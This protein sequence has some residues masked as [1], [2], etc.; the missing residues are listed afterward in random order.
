MAKNCHIIRQSFLLLLIFS[1]I[2][3]IKHLLGVADVYW[4]TNSC[5]PKQCLSLVYSN[6]PMLFS[7]VVCR[8][9]CLTNTPSMCQ[10]KVKFNY[11]ET[12]WYLISKLCR[13]RVCHIVSIATQAFDWRLTFFSLMSIDHIGL[14][15]FHLLEVH[16]RR[17]GQRS[18]Q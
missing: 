12:N 5:F 10:Y 13:N 6:C 15:L 8:V 2:T 3:V 11:N 1:K 4:R 16:T 18:Q 14:R 9:C 17:L 7:L